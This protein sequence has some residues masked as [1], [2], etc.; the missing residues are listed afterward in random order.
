ML[1]HHLADTYGIDV[2]GAEELDERTVRIDRGD[3]PKWIARLID[4]AEHARGD[5][6]ILEALDRHGFPAERLAAVQPVSEYDGQAVLVTEYVPSVPRAE[7]REAIVRAGGLR[8]LGDLQ[9]RLHA[10]PTTTTQP[11][12][13]WHHLA[14][15][16]PSAEL[17]ALRELVGEN[18]ELLAAV[19]G[20]SDGADLP[21][22]VIHPD[23]VL[24]NVVASSDGVMVL[25]DWSGSG[26][27]PR[28]WA[29][30]FTLWSVGFNE[31]LGRVDRLAAGYARH[32]RLEP[33]ELDAL[34]ALIR[35]RPIVFT[36]WAIATG[37]RPARG[38]ETELRR[39]HALAAAIG[40][41]A[42]ASLSGAR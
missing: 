2:V 5:A 7:R 37:R 16:A 36:A 11:G 19:D 23:F 18:A 3:G 12:G 40:E 17:A 4:T 22:A 13:A 29:L 33:E 30:A 42:Q 41:R 28:A 26:R 21:E 8:A 31:D 10:H 39:I 15:G 34:P 9:G 6:A 35:V 24:A 38:L 1:E 27:G 20:L 25:V 32:V 14:Y